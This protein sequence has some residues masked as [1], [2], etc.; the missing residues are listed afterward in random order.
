METNKSCAGFIEE[1]EK[2]VEDTFQRLKQLKDQL[3]QLKEQYKQLEEQQTLNV[4]VNQQSVKIVPQ[5]EA[6]VKIKVEE[7][8]VE[9]FDHP[10]VVPSAVNNSDENNQNAQGVQPGGNAVDVFLLNQNAVSA[11]YVRPSFD[12]MEVADEDETRRVSA[13][14]GHDDT[15]SSSDVSSNFSSD[16]SSDFSSDFSNNFDT[17]FG[18]DENVDSFVCHLREVQINIVEDVHEITSKMISE[19]VLMNAKFSNMVVDNFIDLYSLIID[20]MESKVTLGQAMEGMDVTIQV[21]SIKMQE[22][23]ES[24]Q[25]KQ[26]TMFNRFLKNFEETISDKAEEIYDMLS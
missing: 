18:S 10:Q 20:F 21:T 6:N 12:Q 17:D 2:E 14:R 16:V 13:K 26:A 19:T 3:K 11:E 25:H 4:N 15:E 1:L 7:S 24:M 8:N 5:Y 22:A 23:F 9:S